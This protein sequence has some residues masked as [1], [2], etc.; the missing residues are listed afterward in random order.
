MSTF[1]AAGLIATVGILTTLASHANA[2]PPSEGVSLF[3][4]LEVTPGGTFS[5]G[6]GWSRRSNEL[7]TIYDNTSVNHYQTGAPADYTFAATVSSAGDSLSLELPRVGPSQY[8]PRFQYLERMEF[9][10]SHLDRLPS[11]VTVDVYHLFY[12]DVVTWTGTGD[13]PVRSLLGGFYMAD[14]FLPPCD[15]G[16]CVTSFTVTDLWQLGIVLDDNAL[17]YIQTISFPNSGGIPIEDPNALMVF[18]GD[19]TPAGTEGKAAVGESTD[20][21]FVVGNCFYGFGGTPNVA[22]MRL[23]LDVI[24]CDSD[25]DGSGFSDIDD[26]GAFVVAFEA[27]C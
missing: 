4:P 2:Q 13:C 18:S 10:L 11:G 23:K 21:I 16:T 25:F 5:A 17:A 9:S 6:D 27:G 7:I 15:P 1:T 19:G 20:Q 3:G 14:V 22:N 8:G 24:Y 26:F 12:D